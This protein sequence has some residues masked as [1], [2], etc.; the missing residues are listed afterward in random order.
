MALTVRSNPLR[1][2]VL[3]LCVVLLVFAPWAPRPA[4][5]ASLP[6]STPR[7]GSSRFT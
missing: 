7:S 4:A 2:S 1:T 6:T 5:A 3:G